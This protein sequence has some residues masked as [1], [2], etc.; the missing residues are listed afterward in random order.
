MSLAVSADGREPRA[1]AVNFSSMRR[2]K[3][4]GC[5]PDVTLR[6]IAAVA[7]PRHYA[8]GDLVFRHEDPGS[9]VFLLV[10]GGV[11]FFVTDREGAKVPLESPIDGGIFGEI[12]VLTGGKRTTSARVT[13]DASMLEIE[14]EAFRRLLAGHP[15]LAGLVLQETARRLGRSSR[16]FGLATVGD[17]VD[18]FDEGLTPTERRLQAVA[19]FCSSLRLIYFNVALVAAWL[20]GASYLGARPL[21][22]PAYN[23]LALFLAVEALGAACIVLHGQSLRERFERIRAAQEY[24]INDR[25]EQSV[26]Q[27]VSR[28]GRI[29]GLLG[30]ASSA[31]DT[32]T[33]RSDIASS[34]CITAPD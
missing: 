16:Y 34:P 21:D 15:E 25:T 4:L 22:G 7:A 3:L 2:M 20:G 28:L 9:S 1:A 11:E 19:G 14:G 32:Q 27:L 33:P 17:P 23:L 6:E 26:R 24:R 10:S 13:H 5:L 12:A 8:S 29:E 30:V 18:L 31:A